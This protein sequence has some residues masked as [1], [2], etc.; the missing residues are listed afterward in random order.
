[1]ASSL[2]AIM[3]EREE[4]NVAVRRKVDV[5]GLG[6]GGTRSVSAD[7]A[8]LGTVTRRPTADR[9]RS[10]N[11]PPRPRKKKKKKH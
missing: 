2:V 4:I 11:A 7:D 1:V 6:D 8:A 9:P 10:G 3:K 5:R